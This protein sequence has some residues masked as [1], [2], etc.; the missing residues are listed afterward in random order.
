MWKSG[1]YIGLSQ[2]ISVDDK[3]VPL[4]LLQLAK[5]EWLNTVRKLVE[6]VDLMTTEAEPISIFF[7]WGQFNENNYSEV[8]NYID[9]LIDDDTKLKSFLDCFKAG[10]TLSG[11]EY[12]I[13]DIQKIITRIEEL[14]DQTISSKNIIIHLNSIKNKN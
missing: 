1:K 8:Q 5:N 11:I 6:S 7:R 4:Q 3:D 9:K 13:K 2:N 10:K 12:L 14:N